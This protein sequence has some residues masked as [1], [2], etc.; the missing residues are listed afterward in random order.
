MKYVI[1]GGAGHTSKP[2]VLALLDAG[3]EVKVIGRNADNLKELVDKGAQAAIGSV[4]D[5]D[6]LKKSFA[7]ADAAYTL[8]PPN[9]RVAD[10][11][12]YITQVGINYGHALK[13]A[14]ISFVVNLSS[15]GGHM[16][17]GAGP[18]S[19]LHNVE[20]TLN[21]LT[22]VNIIHLRPGYF[23]ENWFGSVGMVKNNNIIGGNY[24][25]GTK[26]VLAAP[27]DIA[28]VAAEELMNLNFKG[29][30]IRYVCSDERTTAD[31]AKVLGTAV[32]KPELPWVEFTDEQTLD[33]MVQ[34][35]LPQE[36]AKNY[37]EMGAALR[38][39]RM[40]EDYWKQ[41]PDHL[42]QTKLEDFAKKFAAAYDAS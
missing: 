36:I 2:I 26:M 5:L 11:K 4:E 6:F 22:D 32:G 9:L 18:V 23:F 21:Q 20:E 16:A 12:G 25:P 39:G 42:G 34:A 38:T 24:G 31:I 17:E 14:G 33:G 8:V 28:S 40:A 3:Q 35:G 19:G 13:S 41:H 7:D 10:W 30:S 27:A 15:I 1:T 37:T 29:H